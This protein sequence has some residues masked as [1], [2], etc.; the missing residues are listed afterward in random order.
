MI[1]QIF[2]FRLG[3]VLLAGVVLSMTGCGEKIAIRYYLLE[4]IPPSGEQTVAV[5]PDDRN[6]LIGVGPVTIPEYLKRTE[7]VT[8]DSRNQLE[9]ADYHQWA[10]PL[11]NSV[12]RVLTANLSGLL[13]G[14]RI[15]VLPWRATSDIDYQIKV[16]LIRLD[17]EN[18]DRAFLEARWVVLTG[19]SREL[20]SLH[21]SHFETPITV[22][23]DETERF[24]AVVAA[25]SH[26]LERLSREMA[27]RIQSLYG[28]Q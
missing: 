28:V 10:E 9:L 23:T 3:I 21:S 5:T 11:E 16:D 19:K 15:T 22:T 12:M 20:V 27:D 2:M 4:S 17:S 25:Q 18:A 1:R 24:N 14:E 8:R 26:L 13:P 7:M 6:L